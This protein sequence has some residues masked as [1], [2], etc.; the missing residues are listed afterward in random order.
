MC[1]TNIPLTAKWGWV[2]E[3]GGQ[4]P[5]RRAGRDK[6]GEDRIWPTWDHEGKKGQVEDIQES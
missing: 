4:R 6:V 3:M 5:R 1:F 2:R